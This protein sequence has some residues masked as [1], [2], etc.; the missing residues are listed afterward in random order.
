MN[1]PVIFMAKGGKL[2]PRLRGTN[3]VT[4]YGLP[5]GSFVI[6]NKVSYVDDETWSKLVKVVAPGIRKMKASNFS[7]DFTILFSIY[8]TIH[9]CTSKISSYDL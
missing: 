9:L 6:P 4:R 3:L 1:A 2:H 7:Y 5:E 8:L